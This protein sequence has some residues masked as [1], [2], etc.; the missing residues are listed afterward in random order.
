MSQNILS[1]IEYSILYDLL[2]N[3]VQPRDTLG[4][5]RD[6]DN[7][8]KYTGGGLTAPQKMLGPKEFCVKN[9]WVRKNAGSKKF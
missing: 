9:C 5:N 8:C 3:L 7:V 4:V 6:L 1:K 2:L